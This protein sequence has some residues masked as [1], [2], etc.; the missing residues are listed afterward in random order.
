MANSKPA[1][2]LDSRSS[3]ASPEIVFDP[4]IIPAWWPLDD[5]GHAVRW[6]FRTMRPDI[7]DLRH[8]SHHVH[9]LDIRSK[10]FA[11]VAVHSV[12]K[13]SSKRSPFLHVSL[14]FEGAR[15]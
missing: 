1:R 2:D 13:G 15:R 11:E 12:T 4:L 5:Q 10:E 14:T 9:T 8:E 7:D 3:C 6:V